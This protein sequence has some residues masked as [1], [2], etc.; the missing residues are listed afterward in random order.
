[1]A[2]EQPGHEPPP[3]PAEHLRSLRS[4]A[5]SVKALG[6]LGVGLLALALALTFAS[7]SALWFLLYPLLIV[8]GLAALATAIALL[9]RFF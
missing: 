4:E 1:M 2:R 5:R 3:E 6:L 8:G 9:M 7:S